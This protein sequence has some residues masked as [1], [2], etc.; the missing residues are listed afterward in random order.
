MT[1]ILACHVHN[2]LSGPD[3]MRLM[4]IVEKGL[5][6]EGIFYLRSEVSVIDPYDFDAVDLHAI[7]PI[8]LL[9]KKISYPFTV[10]SNAPI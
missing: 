6:D 4:R 3:F 7:D 10:N 8:K 2:E 9:A 1:L 5:A